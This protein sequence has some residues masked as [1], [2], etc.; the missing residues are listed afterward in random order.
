MALPEVV[1]VPVAVAFSTCAP[2][3]VAVMATFN[4][5][6]LPAMY[7]GLM[8]SVTVAP[9]LKAVNLEPTLGL[10]LSAVAMSSAIFVAV[11][12]VACVKGTVTTVAVK[13]ALVTVKER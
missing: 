9:V 8:I 11:V 7:S 1:I 12:C 10:L 5:L 13:S 3:S 6:S 2:V 4:V